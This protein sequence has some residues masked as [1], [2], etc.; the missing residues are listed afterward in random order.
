MQN[1]GKHVSEGGNVAGGD[2]EVGAKSAAW[3]R[4]ICGRVEKSDHAAWGKGICTLARRRDLV[5]GV[6]GGY[7]VRVKNSRATIRICEVAKQRRRDVH[8]YLGDMWM[9]GSLAGTFRQAFFLCDT[10]TIEIA[11]FV[12]SL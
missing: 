11:K 8:W 6:V 3:Q 5:M 7:V 10:S 9:G 4:M 2:R 1:N 12:A